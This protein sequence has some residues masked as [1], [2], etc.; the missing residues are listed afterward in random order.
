MS[1]VRVIQT[2]WTLVSPAVPDRRTR[3][4]SKAYTGLFQRRSSRIKVPV[5]AFLVETEGRLTLID[6]GWSAQAALHPLRHMGFGLWFASE[7]VLTE[8][9][10]VSRQLERLGIAPK[11]L[12]AVVFTHL[13]CDHVSGVDTLRTARRIMVSPQELAAA[14]GKDIRYRPNFWRGVDFEEM[15]FRFDERS[16]FQQSCDVYGDG[17][18]VAHF[19]PGHSKGSVAIVANDFET[20]RF[21]V[22]AGDD[23]YNKKSWDELALP[24]PLVNADE[25]KRSLSWIRDLRSHEACAGVFAAHDPA[26][27][28]GVYEF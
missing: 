15:D 16:P 25:M 8:E 17:S 11:D 9:A 2:G 24:G 19:T 21:V 26:V 7:P 10:A 22:L 12:D 1:Y 23:G 14:R 28:P 4:W 5:K 6:A 3:T 20:G 13:D 18:V 27:E